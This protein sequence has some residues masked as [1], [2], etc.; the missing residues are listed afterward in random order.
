VLHQC[1][2]VSQPTR[3]TVAPDAGLI[4]QLARDAI[5]A[6]PVAYRH[7]AD[8]VALRVEEFAPEHLLDDL[9]VDDAFE[10]T[11]LYEG[12]PVTEKSVMDQPWQPDT[13]W[14]FRR[15]ILDEWADRGTVPLGKLVA[16]VL[17]HELAHHFGWSDEDIAEIDRWWE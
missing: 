10:I 11:G 1:L 3:D 4:E 14:L 2:L 5:A 15:P 16:H 12:T 9:E 8:Q 17:I 7:A 13:I 6:L